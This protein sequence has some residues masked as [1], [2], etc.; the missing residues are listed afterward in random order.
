MEAMI[1]IAFNIYCCA[2]SPWSSSKAFPKHQLLAKRVTTDMLG[3][4]L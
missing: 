4:L 3:W 1:I 2:A